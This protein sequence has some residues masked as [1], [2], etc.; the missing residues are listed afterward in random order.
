M[1]K[2]NIGILI[3]I[4]LICIMGI[5]MLQLNL[6]SSD[7]KNGDKNS[8]IIGD[9]EV[10]YIDLTDDSV[11]Y[12][13]ALQNHTTDNKNNEVVDN[14][15]N[16]SKLEENYNENKQEDRNEK[17]NNNNRKNEKYY[18]VQIDLKN[19][20]VIADNETTKSIQDFFELDEAQAEEITNSEEKLKNYLRENMMGDIDFSENVINIEN[21]FSTLAIIIKTDKFG[22]IRSLGNVNYVTKVA[23]TVY[24][25]HYK[26]AEDTKAGYD[27]LNEDPN[28]E[29]VVKDYKLKSQ[30]N[31]ENIEEV[32]ENSINDVQE[33]SANQ[34]RA[35]SKHQKYAW[36]VKTTGMYKYAQY[37]DKMTSRKTVRVAVLDTG[38]RTTHEIFKDRLDMK[39]AGAY[40][41][42]WGYGTTSDVSDEEGHGTMVA[43]IIAEATPKNVKIVP[44]KCDRFVSSELEALRALANN[45]D[46]INRS[47]GGYY[48]EE[49]KKIENEVLKEVKDKNTIIVCSSGNDGNKT[50]YDYENHYPSASPYTISVG[51]TD[52]NRK[53]AGFS[54]YASSVDFT[55]PGVDLV[56]P[57]FQGDDTYATASGT[58]LSSPLI[59]A[60]FALLKTE[61]PN[62][63]V[64]QLKTEL[65]K[66]CDDLGT[67]GKDKYYGYGEVNFFKNKFSTPAIVEADSEQKWGKDEIFT[68]SIEG[69]NNI[70]HYYCSSDSTVPSNEKWGEIPFK[71][72]GVHKIFNMNFTAQRNGTKYIWLKDENGNVSE[73]FE[74]EVK[75]IDDINPVIVE[76]LSDFNITPNAFNVKFKAYDKQTGIKKIKWYFK[77]ENEENYATTETVFDEP[78]LET[79]ERTLQRTGIR[80]NSK[81]Q[82]YAEIYDAADNCQKTNEIT[83]ITPKSSVSSISVQTNPIKTTYIKGEKLDLT[84]GKIKVT[85]EDKTTEIIDMKDADVSVTGYNQQTLGEQVLTVQY[86]GK[87]TTFKIKVANNITSIVMQTNPTKTTYIKGEE[88]DL[89]GGKI[90]ITHEDKTTEIIDMKDTNVSVTGYNKQILGEQV[91]IVKYKEKTTTFKVKVKNDLV[92][93]EIEDK[94]NKTIYFIGENFEKEG[95]KVVATYEDNTKK[96]ITTYDIVGGENLNLETANVIIKYTENEINKTVEQKIKVLDKSKEQLIIEGQEEAQT[97]ET[98]ILK[99]LL[100]SQQKIFSLSG[101]IRKNE[102]ITNMKLIEQ[103]GWKI[104]YNSVTGEFDLEKTVGAQTEEI[105]NI[106][107]TTSDKEGKGEITL[108]NIKMMTEDAEMIKFDDV[109]NSIQIQK[110]VILTGIKIVK[111]PD[112]LVYTVG[113]EFDKQGMEILAEYSNGTSK[114][115]TNY[116]YSPSESLKINDNKIVISYAEE[117]ITQKVELE[118][119]VNNVPEKKDNNAE[120]MDNADNYNSENTNDSGNKKDSTIANTE[121]PK[122][123]FEKKIIC[124]GVIVISTAAIYLYLVI[125]KYK[126][127]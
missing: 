21:A 17:N 100:Y 84:G 50:G 20:I 78:T 54:N 107:I 94:P 37:T 41:K 38:V 44:V 98:Q 118:I 6:K 39:Y 47:F 51:A 89:T 76:N 13:N 123:G 95:M 46:I 119:E 64:D 117:G 9:K 126:N 65:I 22:E 120:N 104:K 63:S 93:I 31:T 80:S 75:Y 48:S 60:A 23:D 4:I 91:L 125:K 67:A 111:N 99:V 32:T 105:L 96:E 79:I 35:T 26:N 29:M 83:V 28:V 15:K 108:T 92:K 19:N 81:T 88:L 11:D 114:K 10:M 42:D 52:I 62:Y 45:V 106:E 5:V 82:I 116:T 14:S 30:E 36:G 61:N 74:Y 85:Y 109:Q 101:I 124:I 113:E 77:Q 73:R 49:I 87:T 33:A 27:L 68:V 24:V 18:N 34:E 69:I 53:I 2:R 102:Y 59:S 12:K 1:R 127:I 115:I 55:A 25:I 72:S 43:G 97:E 90:K 3:V 7:K 8:M 71:N 122:A 58:S 16:E 121:L 57:C 112:K 103:N 56:L 70:T 66:H 86:Q 40:G 110:P